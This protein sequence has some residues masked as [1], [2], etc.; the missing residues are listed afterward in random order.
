MRLPNVRAHTREET[1]IHTSKKKD[2]R[3]EKKGWGEMGGKK[4]GIRVERKKRKGKGH[5]ENEGKKENKRGKR[6]E[7]WGGGQKKKRK[8]E[9]DGFTI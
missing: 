3:V 8:R 6:E 2:E 7:K 5:K 1:R 9:G 4:Q